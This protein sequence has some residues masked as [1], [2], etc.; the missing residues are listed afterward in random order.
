MMNFNFLRKKS[1]GI[2]LGNNNTLVNDGKR[3]LIA[4]P[5]CIVLDKTKD[6]VKAVGT[7][8]Y[9]M[10]EKTHHNRALVA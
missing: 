4:Q 6:T 8:A 1:F 9:D 2:D 7:D 3:V 10:F 5:S